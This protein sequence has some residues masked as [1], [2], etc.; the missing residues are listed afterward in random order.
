MD[1][2][3]N[4]RLDFS[5]NQVTTKVEMIDF[6]TNQK[7]VVVRLLFTLIGTSAS[8]IQDQYEDYE[9]Y[10]EHHEPY[11]SI[12]VIENSKA[13]NSNKFTEG[14]YIYMPPTFSKWSLMD[15]EDLKHCLVI[16][17]YMDK[18][19]A[20]FLGFTYVANKIKILL[21]EYGYEKLVVLGCNTM[22]MVLAKCLQNENVSI[23]VV[24]DNRDFDI[25]DNQTDKLSCIE[26]S[27]LKSNEFDSING[28]LLKLSN[29]QWAIDLQN[30]LCENL[31][32]IE[33]LDDDI[34]SQKMNI[35]E[36]TEIAEY[37]KTYVQSYQDLIIQHVH[38]EHFSNT[39]NMIQGYKFKGKAIVY[40]W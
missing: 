40:D 15:K 38:S 25:Q 18:V 9:G 2:E 5:K 21:K 8:T 11:A 27:S 1:S 4:I 37:M 26:Y 6:R 3:C 12:G 13:I 32:N 23:T 7:Y 30:E 17:S 33:L 16:P 22:T 14:T 20:L 34:W 29:K 24:C 31:Q 39:Y 10:K 35:D 19:D 36:I 28:I